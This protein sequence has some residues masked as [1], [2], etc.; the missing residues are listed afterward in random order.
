MSTPDT[1]FP[2]TTTITT[3]PAPPPPHPH[4]PFPH[5]QEALPGQ[6]GA[7]GGACVYAGHVPLLHRWGDCLIGLKV[8]LSA[9]E[10]A[11]QTRCCWACCSSSQAGPHHSLRTSSQSA[12]VPLLRCGRQPRTWLTL[13]CPAVACCAIWYH[14]NHAEPRR[15]P[16]SAEPS[17]AA[18]R[19]AC[20]AADESHLDT[21]LEGVIAL[22]L[23][24]TAV[25][26]VVSGTIPTS[27]YVSLEAQLHCVW[28]MHAWLSMH[29]HRCPMCEQPERALHAASA[30]PATHPRCPRCCTIQACPLLPL[31]PA[32]A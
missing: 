17:P 31:P 23:A 12:G 13:P 29:G 5:P 15:A 11:T 7:A 1:I 16:V 9:T 20:W 26:F 6:H 28:C 27:S 8:C 32:N 18:P 24:L 25:Q 2:T 10:L 21:R 30:H 22:F 14:T 4:P 3:Q 19:C